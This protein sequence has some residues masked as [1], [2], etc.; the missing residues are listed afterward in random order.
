MFDLSLSLGLNLGLLNFSSATLSILKLVII[1][2]SIVFPTCAPFSCEQIWEDLLVSVMVAL[3]RKWENGS[4]PALLRCFGIHVNT[5]GP[6]RRQPYDIWFSRWNEFCL[7][8]FDYSLFKRFL[9]LCKILDNA[10]TLWTLHVEVLKF[11]V[12]PKI[13]T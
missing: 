11:H 7:K 2:L 13:Y 3:R 1:C 6:I 4:H 5:S 9:S 8:N 10:R 12:N